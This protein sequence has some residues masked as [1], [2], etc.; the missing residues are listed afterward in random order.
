MASQEY[1]VKEH[2]EDSFEKK[3][4]KSIQMRKESKKKILMRGKK[5]KAFQVD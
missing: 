2:E 1:G 3:N 4:K 5:M